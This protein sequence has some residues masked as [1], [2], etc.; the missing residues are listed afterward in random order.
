MVMYVSNTKNLPKKAEDQKPDSK[1]YEIRWKEEK[2]VFIE[3]TDDIQA[4]N[5][6]HELL[7][8]GEDIGELMNISNDSVKVKE[9][10]ED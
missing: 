4:Y 3:A 8:N 7:Y 2:R 1:K 9:V 10:E 5:Q 6:F